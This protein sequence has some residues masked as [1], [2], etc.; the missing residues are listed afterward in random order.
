M[1]R[2]ILF[3]IILGLLLGCKGEVGQKCQKGG[4]C[5]DNYSYCNDTGVCERCGYLNQPCCPTSGCF[6]DN[7]KCESGVCIE[8]GKEGQPCCFGEE[9]CGSQGMNYCNAGVCERCGTTGEVCCPGENPC[10][11]PEY[12]VCKAGICESCG[13]YNDPC[14]AGSLCREGYNC[15]PDNS[16]VSCGGWDEN[17]CLVGTS[18]QSWLAPI[19]G[20]CG[21]PF[22]ANPGT[23]ADLC[24]SAKIEDTSY[25]KDWC[26]WHA[27]YFKQDLSL[28]DQI[29]WGD[30]RDKCSQNENPEDYY[31][32]TTFN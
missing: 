29:L 16:C 11:L 15:M 21:S 1:N 25:G 7:Q 22:K 6:S 17:A 28:C 4:L 24:L 19:D 8:C 32:W 13:G 14:C 9:P 23:D 26:Y 10:F 30:A 18:C 12:D 27:A 31:I 5:K 20:V 3:L 2:K